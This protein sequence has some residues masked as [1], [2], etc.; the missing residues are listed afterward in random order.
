ML[1]I[2]FLKIEVKVCC[3]K[4]GG[5]DMGGVERS[6]GVSVCGKDEWA[7]GE[8]LSNEFSVIVKVCGWGVWRVW[9]GG[10]GCVWKG[11]RG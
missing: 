9:W 7:V 4:C 6:E 3:W 2:N 5:E 8:D 11:V 10:Y 1:N